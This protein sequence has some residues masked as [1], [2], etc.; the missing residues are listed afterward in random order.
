VTAGVLGD[1]NAVYTPGVSEKRGSVTTF[2][3]SGL[4]NAGA[5]TN[6][7]GSGDASVQAARDYDAFGSATA[8]S[9]TWQGPFGHAGQ[10]GYQGAAP[11]DPLGGLH[12]LGYRYYDPSLCR[13]L[14]RDP[15]GDGS[16]WYA[17]CGNDPV[18]LA[19][20]S[21][22]RSLWYG[23][24]AGIIS[25]PI[26]AS[27]F[28]GFGYDF[29]TRNVGVIID[30]G[31]GVGAG[32]SLGPSISANYSHDQAIGD[33]SNYTWPGKETDGR[34]IGLAIPHGAVELEYREKDG[35]IDGGGIGAEVAPPGFNSH[36][37][38]AGVYKEWRRAYITNVSEIVG[39][40]LRDIAPRPGTD[41]HYL[42]RDFRS[43]RERSFQR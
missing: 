1:G 21:G 38:G 33:N 9:G 34:V 35:T 26:S 12:L 13:F 23:G 28:L 29:D 11:S 3:H 43:A 39:E 5:Q 15:V 16:N 41:P 25:T 30:V 4:K 8:S 31:G 14:T 2:S 19:D 27:F 24:G 32:L 36:G 10:F 7:P 42:P 22:L 40:F 6:A 37:V 17:Y 20:P 18:A